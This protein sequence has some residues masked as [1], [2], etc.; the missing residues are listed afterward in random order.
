MT[1]PSQAHTN[2][3]RRVIEEALEAQPQPYFNIAFVGLATF[4][5]IV[6]LALL[7]QWLH[8][9]LVVALAAAYVWFVLR[10]PS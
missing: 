6:A 4:F 5:L 2:L 10:R 9:G 1:K 3:A 7:Q 8:L